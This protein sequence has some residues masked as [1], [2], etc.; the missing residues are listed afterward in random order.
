[1][2]RNQGLLQVEQTRIIAI[3]RGIGRKHILKVAEA[4]HEAGVTVM[5][6]T[7]NSEGALDMVK[8]LQREF[9]DVM[10]I[11]AGT[12]LTVG[13]AR[14][15]AESGASFLVTP[16]TDE[17]TIRYAVESELPIFPGAMTPTEIVR[18]WKAG[19]TAV[20]VFPCSGVGMTYIK[21]VQGPLSHIPMVAVGGVT[22][23]SIV[24][25][26]NLPCYAVGIGGSL[27][28][29]KEVESGNYAWVSDKAKR[30]VQ[31]AQG[32]GKH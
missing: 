10:F 6:V 32:T 25:Y 26:L 18:A 13:D 29:V 31:R 20:K 30:L 14:D 23:D 19:A 17:E 11:G 12:V 5:E 2:N 1:M 28:N 27:I 15:A 8:D 22:E 16:N 4:L 9:G 7:L 24:D 21:E 3:I